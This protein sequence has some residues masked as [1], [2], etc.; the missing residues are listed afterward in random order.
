[1]GRLC[2][3]LPGAAWVQDQEE[4]PLALGWGDHH[5]PRSPVPAGCPPGTQRQPGA[6]PA[7]PSSLPYDP[8]EICVLQHFPGVSHPLKNKVDRSPLLP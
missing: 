1:M 2:G 4:S 3:Q 8:P 5:H 7:A 6:V